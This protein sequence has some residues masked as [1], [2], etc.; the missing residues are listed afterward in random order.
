MTPEELLTRA[1]DQ[2]G[3][4]RVFGQTVERDGNLVVPVA[5]AVGGGGGGTGPDIQ[6]TGGDGFAGIVRGIGVYSTTNGEVRFIPVIDVAA[7]AAIALLLTRTL[8]RAR[9]GPSLRR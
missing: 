3:V 7:L 5:V 4:R 2:L 9:R 1:G 6:G 8:F